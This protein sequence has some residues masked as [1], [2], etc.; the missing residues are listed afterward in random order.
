MIVYMILYI[1]HKFVVLVDL[2]RQESLSV[3]YVL[4]N[5][6]GMDVEWLRCRSSDFN[7]NALER[8]GVF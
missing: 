3:V 8:H 5:I 4:T 1:E 7:F 2:R 6:E